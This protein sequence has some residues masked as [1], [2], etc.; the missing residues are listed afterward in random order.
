MNV[1]DT[2]YDSHN[3]FSRARHA[4]HDGGHEDDDDVGFPNKSS[5]FLRPTQLL[6][7]WEQGGSH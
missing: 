7:L 6:K 5:D 4:D 1:M 3:Q 2:Q